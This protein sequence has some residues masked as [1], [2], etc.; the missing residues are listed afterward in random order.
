MATCALWPYRHD[1]NHTSWMTVVTPTDRQKSFRNRCVKVLVAFLCCSLV[2][3]ILC[4]YRGFCHRTESDLKSKLWHSQGSWTK[5]YLVSFKFWTCPN[6][7]NI[8]P[9]QQPLGRWQQ[10]CEVS[11]PSK[12]PAKGNGQE[13][14]AKCKLWPWPWR[15][16]PESRSWYYCL[17][18]YQYPTWQWGVMARTWF[19]Y[20][21]TVTL[22]SEIWPWV[23]V[24]RS[25]SWHTL[26]SWT[27]IMWN[28]IQIQLGSEELWPGH[29]FWVCVHCYL[30]LGD[31]TLGQ[32]HDTPLGHG[33]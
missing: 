27:T 5:P 3:W 31:M 23:K 22:T 9:Q 30:D 24:P 21:C 17:I 2:F 32:C 14:I 10:L 25:R 8:P 28:I 33:Q 15:Y 29:G 20:K 6:W 12:L 18:Q 4:W 11:F 26:E 13:E 19:R 1:P 7:T 16:D